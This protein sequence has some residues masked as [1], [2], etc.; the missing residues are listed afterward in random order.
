MI[1]VQPP[2]K[3]LYTSKI[4]NVVMSRKRIRV[5]FIGI[6][7]VASAVIQGLLYYS[8][9]PE[10]EGLWHP[11]VGGYRVNDIEV[12]V[13]LDVDPKKVGKDVS[14]AL[15]TDPNS[16]EKLVDIPNTGITVEKGLLEDELN[17]YLASKIR[18]V[19]QDR[20]GVVE[21]LK[22]NRV[23]VVVNAISSG[24]DRTSAAYSEVAC[25]A[26]A[27][28]VNIT[29][30]SVATNPA[31]VEKFKERKLVIV[32]DDLMSQLGGTALHRGIVT[33]LKSRGIKPVKSY[34]LDVGGGLETLNTMYE[35][36]RDFKKR[37]KTASIIEEVE[38]GWEV[39]SG[40]TDYVDFLGNNRI[41][42]F[43]FNAIGFMGSNFTI[44]VSLRS[45]DGANAG[46]VILDVVRAVARAKDDG[47][48]GN[49]SEISNYG[50]KKTLEKKRIA[51]ATDVF[52]SKYCR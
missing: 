40:T 32:G 22:G 24:L 11:L 39:V 13:A 45:N 23:D 44:N 52:E 30:A 49:V 38:E 33:F 15:F 2:W 28:F 14:E 47:C 12:A 50:F 43:Q 16:F 35:D 36:L 18:P 6:G 20:E 1:Y 25:E 29:P 19:K 9:N 21:C 34:Q 42:Y 7:N 48:S 31:L 26:G 8:S 37:V 5:A 51:E 27:S 3:I 10:T 46:N 4:E 41:T 17:P